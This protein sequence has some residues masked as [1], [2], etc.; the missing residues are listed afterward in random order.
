MNKGY[1][2]KKQTFNPR[3]VKPVVTFRASRICE[4]AKLFYCSKIWPYTDAH[5]TSYKCGPTDWKPHCIHIL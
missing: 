5:K 4:K 3:V 1:L 2:C